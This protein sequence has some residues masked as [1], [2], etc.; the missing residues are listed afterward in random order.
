[1]PGNAAQFSPIVSPF[2]CYVAEAAVCGYSKAREHTELFPGGYAPAD[3]VVVPF[4]EHVAEGV[5]GK[6]RDFVL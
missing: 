6:V 1:M 3:V 2:I 5:C 4:T